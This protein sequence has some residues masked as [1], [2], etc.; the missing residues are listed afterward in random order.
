MIAC[1]PLQTAW[2]WIIVVLLTSCIYEASDDNND[3][4]VNPNY[5][6]A[7]VQIDLQNA[8]DTIDVGGPVTFNYDITGYAVEKPYN[9]YFIAGDTIRQLTNFS[10]TINYDPGTAEKY[11]AMTIRVSTNTGTNSLADKNNIERI[12]YERSWVLNINTINPDKGPDI[13]SIN[14][15]DGS[16]KISWQK[17]NKAN[18]AGYSVYRSGVLIANIQDADISS[19]MDLSYVG[20]HT[21]YRV[22]INLKDNNSVSGNPVDYVTEPSKVIKSEVT[23]DGRLKF[24][25]SACRYPNNFQRYDI[26]ADGANPTNGLPIFSTTN[27]GDTTFT[28]TSSFGQKQLSTVVTYPKN[29]GDGYWDVE[30][31]AFYTF[32]EETDTYEVIATAPAINRYFT[33][34]AELLNAY[35]LDTHELVATAPITRHVLNLV[36]SDDQTTILATDYFKIYQWDAL[37]LSLRN[38]FSSTQFAPNSIKSIGSPNE[39]LLL[40][41]KVTN[42]GLGSILFYNISTSTIEKEYQGNVD[43]GS[44]LQRSSDHQ[45]IIIKER[46]SSRLVKLEADNTMTQKITTSH[47]NLFFHPDDNTKVITGSELERARAPFLYR[48]G[49]RRA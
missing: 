35:A 32:G 6:I 21:T 39:N 31:H 5:P 45:F 26:Y 19:M 47:E 1:I 49:K 38:E 28:F 13:T 7:P 2:I 17:Y 44:S 10:G 24:F 30:G 9:I 23:S 41:G 43:V 12:V 33:R 36:V 14:A 18:F 46:G 22:A 16:L 40:L 37:T 8:G 15:A 42:A 4:Y 25:W 27:I 11:L 34:T 20:G 29:E 3:I 48:T